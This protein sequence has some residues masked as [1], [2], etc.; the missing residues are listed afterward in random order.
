MQN[1]CHYKSIV[2]VI[3]QLLLS[4]FLKMMEVKKW[5]AI[6]FYQ[7]I[8]RVSRKPLD[9]N[10]KKS[11]WPILTN[12]FLRRAVEGSGQ[13]SAERLSVVLIQFASRD[14]RVQLSGN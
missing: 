9:S 2:V 1:H 11:W 14:L 7:V 3:F 6:L 12:R 8:N 4:Q 13:Q 10:K 5:Q